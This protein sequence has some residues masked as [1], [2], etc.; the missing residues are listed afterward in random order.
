MLN[1]L[2]YLALGMKY[3]LH[4]SVDLQCCQMLSY[5]YHYLWKSRTAMPKWVLPKSGLGGLV[6]AAK[7]GP[8]GL[9]LAVKSGPLTIAAGS[10]VRLGLNLVGLGYTVLLL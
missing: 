5:K 6:L 4:A 3:Q 8:G 9:V 2:V 1:A 10:R 7:S